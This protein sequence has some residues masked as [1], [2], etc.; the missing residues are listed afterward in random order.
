[1]RKKSQHRTTFDPHSRKWLVLL[2]LVLFIP[3]AFSF[4]TNHKHRSVWEKRE[5]AQMPVLE[6]VQDIASF[7]SKADL[8]VNDHIGLALDANKLYRKIIFYAF[9]ESPLKKITYGKNGFVYLNSHSTKYRNSNFESTCIRGTAP[10]YL[11]GLTQKLDAIFRHFEQRNYQVSFAIPVTKIAIY[12][13]NLPDNTPANIL[14]AC[15]KYSS[16]NNNLASLDT[17][18][19]GKQDFYY[20]LQE[21]SDL[22]DN[23]HF[24]PKE[25]FHWNGMS[26]HEFSMGLLEQM[27]IT[28]DAS[29]YNEKSISTISAD[30]TDLGFDRQIRA[31]FYPYSGYKVH[32]SSSSPSIVKQHYRNATDYTEFRT[33]NPATEQ[34]ALVLSNSFGAFTVPHL[35]PA[36][37]TLYHVNVNHLAKDE[38]PAFYDQ[39]IDS[40][41]PDRI[42]FIFEDTS[43]IRETAISTIL[44]HIK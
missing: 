26:A 33:A 15:A 18:Y 6:N 30:L 21:L 7:F 37:K 44:E 4:F 14:N 16:G 19:S 20:P 38:G 39:L 23:S 3:T 34:T 9:R 5:L 32:R 31:W 28:V 29:I 1:M 22:K 17:A 13:E 41:D 10:K 25:N 43:F 2:A 35:A 42:I 8:Y 12:P 24:Y 40:L 36:F 27:G 11:P